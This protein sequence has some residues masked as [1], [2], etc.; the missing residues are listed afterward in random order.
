MNEQ[1]FAAMFANLPPLGY[2]EAP[3][4]TWPRH[5]LE[6]RKHVANGDDVR[7]FTRWSTVYATMFVGDIPEVNGMMRDLI[8]ENNFMRWKT[9][10]TEDTYGCP[11][12]LK[13]Y[14]FTSGNLVRQAYDLLQ[15][16][17]VTG[18]KTETLERI[19][20]FGGGYGAMSAVVRRLGFTGDYYIY[21]LPEFLILHEYYLSNLGFEVKPKEV[22]SHDRFQM[23]PDNVDLLIACYS[24]SEV[25][26]DLREAFFHT[27]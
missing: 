1:E 14:P 11:S 10:V 16:E 21:D 25:T 8:A 22:D 2:T 19:V 5:R 12:R 9:A 18:I 7:E 3:D 4:W 20:E 13:Q 24:M 26:R 17:K 15:F 27:V 6:M 23:T